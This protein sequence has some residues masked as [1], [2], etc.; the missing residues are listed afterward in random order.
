MTPWFAG[1]RLLGCATEP[2]SVQDAPATGGCGTCIVSC[3]SNE[4]TTATVTDAG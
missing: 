1:K 3:L 2:A 4:T